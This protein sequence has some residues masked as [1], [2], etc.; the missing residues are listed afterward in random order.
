MRSL[1]KLVLFLGWC[2]SSSGAHELAL[3]YSID[4][5]RYK[6]ISKPRDS[7]M[8]TIGQEEIDSTKQERDI[9]LIRDICNHLWQSAPPLA[10]FAWHVRKSEDSECFGMF[11]KMI[12]RFHIKFFGHIPELS[13]YSQ[14]L[15]DV[16]KPETIDHCGQRGMVSLKA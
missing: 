12:D 13:L 5:A 11:S 15:L 16:L 9:R 4:G 2:F 14:K 7:W 6:V 10:V 8:N 3:E 1:F